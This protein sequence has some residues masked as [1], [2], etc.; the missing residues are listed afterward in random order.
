VLTCTLADQLKSNEKWLKVA[1]SPQEFCVLADALTSIMA[2][3]YPSAP[4]A[5]IST[6]PTS[7]AGATQPVTAPTVP[8]VTAVAPPIAPTIALPTIVRARPSD[9]AGMV[10][11]PERLNEHNWTTWKEKMMLI[12]KLCGVEE[13]ALGTISPPDPNL[14]P[15]GLRDWKYNNTYAI[16]LVTNNLADS[17]TVHVSGCRTTREVWT[18]LETIH[19]SKGSHTIAAYMRTF[20]HASVNEGEN[21]PEH[22][23]SLKHQCEK[24]NTQGDSRFQISD[25]QFKSVIVASL[26]SSWDIFND[27]QI[28]RDADPKAQISPQKLISLIIDEAERRDIRR[29]Y[30]SN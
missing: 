11:T 12:L 23:S 1:T 18:N 13:Y 22:L 24:I 25:D 30:N 9:Q 29:N 16:M 7:Q 26:P 15:Q 20:Y 6:L 21:I 3:P 27:T 4:A 17:Q 5:T 2:A 10:K 28:G 14:D 19:A 8:V